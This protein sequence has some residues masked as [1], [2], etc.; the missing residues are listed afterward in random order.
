[1]AS[2]D[3]GHALTAY[4]RSMGKGRDHGIDKPAVFSRHTYRPPLN[5]KQKAG[6]IGG[7][8]AK[9]ITPTRATV[10]ERW[11]CLLLG[12]VCIGCGTFGIFG[13]FTKHIAGPPSSAGWL[14]SADIP[15][16]RVT[17][18]LC[19]FMGLLL[20]RCGWSSSD[21]EQKRSEHEK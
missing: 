7:D 16:L 19:L 6:P 21:R 18:L 17:A 14:G 5:A 4:F 1:M 2:G 9:D 20:V 11:I 12:V 10:I 3:K 13:T 15:A 8:E